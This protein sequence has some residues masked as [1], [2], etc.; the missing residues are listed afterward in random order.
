LYSKDERNDLAVQRCM[1]A[2]NEHQIF[3]VEVLDDG[4]NKDP[5]I[6]LHDGGRMQV[7]FEYL[8]IL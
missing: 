6:W 4:A 8:G 1:L 2:L 7:P 3:G 5:G